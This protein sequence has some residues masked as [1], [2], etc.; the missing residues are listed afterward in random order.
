MPT[1]F[2]VVNYTVTGGESDYAI[3]FEGEAPGYLEESHVIYY[4]GTTAQDNADRTFLSANEVRIDPVPIDGTAI[5]FRRETSPTETLVDWAAGASITE[6]N[7]DRMNLQ[8]LYVAQEFADKDL[9]DTSAIAES[10]ENA[11][12]SAAA[13]LVSENNASDHEDDAET[14]KTGAE[15]AEDNAETAEAKAEQWAEEVEDT[16]VETGKYSA[17]HH[18]EKAL[19]AQTAAEAAQ[20]AAETA[21]MPQG[22]IILWSGAISAIP[23]GWYLCDGANSTPDLTDR[24]VIHADADAASTHDVGDTGDGSGTSDGHALTEAE[25]AAHD[26]NYYGDGSIN[27]NGSGVSP[28]TDMNSSNTNNSTTSTGS[29]TEHDHPITDY[30]LNSMH[31]HTL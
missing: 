14:A 26:H 19:D 9:V 3:S 27:T 31:Q 17:L 18:K 5:S 30:N 2:S 29:G 4:I 10:E 13:A 23:T 12:N 6:V 11:A 7:L 15:T 24:F 16:E 25:L 1:Y 20:A 21:A 28:R 22:G 8:M